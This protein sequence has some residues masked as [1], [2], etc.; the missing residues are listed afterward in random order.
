M[1]IHLIFKTYLRSF[2]WASPT[3]FCGSQKNVCYLMGRKQASVAKP[4]DCSFLSHKSNFILFLEEFCHIFTLQVSSASV[5]WMHIRIILETFRK[6]QAQGPPLSDINSI[7]AQA[8]VS[9]NSQVIT[10]N[11]KGWKSQI[12]TTCL[13]LILLMTLIAYAWE[14]H[15]RSIYWKRV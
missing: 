1:V 12:W 7:G 6:H 13:Q 5:H 15:C 8:S 9:F 10:I 11:S 14:C 2:A 3:P 4:H